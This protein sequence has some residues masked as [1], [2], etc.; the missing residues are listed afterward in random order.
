MAFVLA[1]FMMLV[2]IV[3]SRNAEQNSP[4]VTKEHAAA[5][6]TKENIIDALADGTIKYC[7]SDE[8]AL[9]AGGIPID[10]EQLTLLTPED[11]T[12]WRDSVQEFFAPT[13]EQ[14]PEI[15][16]YFRRG[17]Q[18]VDN[19]VIGLKAVD[20]TYCEVVSTSSATLEPYVL[21]NKKY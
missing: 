3:L 17:S 20:G 18:P 2:V 15:G 8:Y 1:L 10:R 21:F 16:I 5:H 11:N 7:D 9:R 4:E 6:I 12:I 13:D 19:F 14:M